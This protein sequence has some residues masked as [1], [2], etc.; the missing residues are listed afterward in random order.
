VRETLRLGTIA[1][2]RVG[3]NWSVLVIVALLVVGLAAGQLPEAYP[4]RSGL[5]YALAGLVG[6]VLFL[7]SLLAHELAH[8][9]IARRNGVDVESIVL[10]LLG[11]VAQLK[12]EPPTPGADFRIAVVGPLTSL[13]L[14]V[15]FGAAGGLASLLGAEGLPVGVLAYLAATNLL[16]AVFNLLPAAPLDGGRVLRAVLWRWRGQ[17]EQAAVTAARAGQV[18]GFALVGLGLLQVLVGAGFGGLWLA[19]IGWFVVNAA[20]A[21]EQQA[22]VGSRLSGM[23]VGDIMARTPVVADADM[24]LA[25]FVD[26]LALTHRFSSY[27]LVDPTG[28]L[29]GL[30]TLNRVRAVP[31]DRRAVTRLRDIACPPEEVPTARPDEPLLAL[32]PRMRGCSDGRAVVLDELGRVVGLVSPTDI[33]RTLQLADLKSFDAY[34]P[35]RGADLT[36]VGPPR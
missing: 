30:V 32:L 5:E 19:L 17:R 6:A 33:S 14:A 36:T 35:P 9:V 29:T 28:R 13:A 23:R 20:T 11:G 15:V 21:E 7:A 18:F 22:R 26:R 24:S 1:G 16:L 27:P 34:P 12:G 10:W 8:A 25:E 2:V 31:P 3:I 4:G